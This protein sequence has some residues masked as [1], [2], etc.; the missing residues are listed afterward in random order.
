MS[1]DHWELTIR[2]LQTKAS[3]YSYKMRTLINIAL[4]YRLHITIH[5]FN[6][7]LVA[8][9]MNL[10]PFCHLSLLLLLLVNPTGK[11]NIFTINTV[12]WTFT[13]SV[14]QGW[15]HMKTR[16]C[17]LFP[18]YGIEPL[19][20]VCYIPPSALRC[21]WGE[22]HRGRR[23]TTLFHQVSGLDPVLELPLLW[24]HPHPQAVGG[25]CCPLLAT[26][27]YCSATSATGFTKW[28]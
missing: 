20:H 8:T 21:A 6:L 12:F 2:H 9:K 3:F 5:S 13:P 22:N 10:A 16:S 15:L 11:S 24:R 23:G 25:D 4:G 18:C 14:T 27:S 28:P 19:C 1:F 26:V 17:K 7:F